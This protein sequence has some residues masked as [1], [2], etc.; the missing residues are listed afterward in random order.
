MVGAA[1]ATVKK[2]KPAKKT[3]PKDE[4]IN[5]PGVDFKEGLRRMLNTP[6]VRTPAKPKK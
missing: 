2:D 3:S 1:N 4:P 6:P 5:V